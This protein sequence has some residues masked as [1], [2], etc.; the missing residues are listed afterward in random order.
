MQ[1][2]LLHSIY[3]HVETEAC[4]WDSCLWVSCKHLTMSWGQNSLERGSVYLTTMS[5]HTHPS[6]VNYHHVA[7]WYSMLSI[8]RLKYSHYSIFCFH[9]RNLQCAAATYTAERKDAHVIHLLIAMLILCRVKESDCSA[10][11]IIYWMLLA[12]VTIMILMYGFW[13]VHCKM[14]LCTVNEFFMVLWK[15]F[16][17]KSIYDGRRYYTKSILLLLLFLA[18]PFRSHHSRS[19]SISPYP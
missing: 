6:K 3:S 17:I 8:G 11:H 2:Y 14:V 1:I 5:K 12:N 15:Y 18:G 9:R 4:Q 7:T 13:C 16:S 19:A 10:K